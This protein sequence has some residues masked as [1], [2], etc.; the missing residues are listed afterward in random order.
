MKRRNHEEHEVPLKLIVMIFV[1]F[2][3]S[4]GVAVAHHGTQA[5][6]IT[7][8]L[9]LR[10]TIMNVEYINPHVELRLDVRSDKGATEQWTIA[11]SPPS[12]MVRKGVARDAITR[13]AIMSVT[14]YAATTAARTFTAIEFTLPDGRSFATSN[15]AFNPLDTSFPRQLPVQKK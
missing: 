11:L 8:T 2:V 5:F 15:A 1:V 13:G 6:D 12:A 14:G 3:V 4:C 10:G 9:T 7:K